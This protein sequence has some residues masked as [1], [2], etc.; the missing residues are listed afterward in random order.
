MLKIDNILV[1]HWHAW[2]GFLISHLV[3]DYC[4]LEVRYEDNFQDLEKYL[5]PNIQAV[6]L[7]INLSCPGQFPAKRQLLINA[8]RKRN[9]RVLNTEIDNI[10]K[11]NLYS[12]LDQASLKSTKAHKTGPVDQMLFI[13]SNLNA[14]GIAEQRLPVELQNALLPEEKPVLGN[15][16]DYFMAKRG[17]IS[18]ELW[19][20]S[21]I[22]IENY[23]YNP[24][25]SFFRVYVFGSSLVVVKAHSP[26]LIKKI[27]GHHHDT[28]LFFKRQEILSQK[29]ELP[30]ALQT[31]I[32]AFCIHHPLAYFCLDIVHDNHDYYIVDLNL[33]PYAG[34]DEQN[35]EALVFLSEGA[36]DYLHMAQHPGMMQ[37]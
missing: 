8:L 13:K 5:T 9:I 34:M 27:S 16:Q 12:V 29:T 1:Y 28:N 10:T 15:G 30:A 14:G 11:R 7:Q 23:I 25:N 18:P 21:N 19:A 31:T 35:T 32:K 17:D 2:K 3:A 24:E 6:L 20:D 26:A 22:V 36:Y 37:R 4:Q 33:T